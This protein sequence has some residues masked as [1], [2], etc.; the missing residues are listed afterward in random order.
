MLNMLTSI[1]APLLIGISAVAPVA[2]PLVLGEEWLPIVP[3]TQVLAMYSLLRSS[4]NAGG[5]VVLAKGR[6]DVSFY[7]N[8][9]LLCFVPAVIFC[10]ASWGSVLTV[11]WSLLALQAILVFVWYVV[12]VRKLLGPCFSG[13]IMA[14][15]IPVLLASVM[16]A[17]VALCGRVIS[18]DTFLPTLLCQIGIGVVTYLG[19]CLIFARSAMQEQLQLLLNR[20]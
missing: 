10:A 12:V 15:G 1:N 3:I 9:M 19:L 14:M 17:V 6:A 8:V 5:S 2:V 18:L 7:W 4:G 16:G 20:A 13:Y 11:A